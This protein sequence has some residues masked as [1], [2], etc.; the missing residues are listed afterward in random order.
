MSLTQ[1]LSAISQEMKKLLIYLLFCLIF[2][3]SSLALPSTQAGDMALGMVTFIPLF[4]SAL[5]FWMSVVLPSEEWWAMKIGLMLVSFIFIFQS[6]QYSV[7]IITDFYGGSTSLI[8]SIG[9]NTQ[10]FTYVYVTI[11]SVFLIWFIKEI[12]MMFSKKKEAGKYEEE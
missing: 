10:I 4:I 5:L 8:D 12:F 6:Y 7:I 1:S 3:I 11:V 2:P 9:Q